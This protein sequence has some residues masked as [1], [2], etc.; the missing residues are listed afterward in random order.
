MK[1][2]FLC[3]TRTLWGSARS[4]FV[5]NDSGTSAHGH[6][7]KILSLRIFFCCTQGNVLNLTHFFKTVPESGDFVSLQRFLSQSRVGFFVFFSWNGW[8]FTCQVPKD[9]LV[10]RSHTEGRRLLCTS[11]H[12]QWFCDFAFRPQRMTQRHVPPLSGVFVPRRQSFIWRSKAG[13]ICQS[14]F[15]ML[16]LCWFD[17][18]ANKWT[19]LPILTLCNACSVCVCVCMKN[20]MMSLRWRSSLT[21]NCS[22]T[23]EVNRITYLTH[24][25]FYSLLIF[26]GSVNFR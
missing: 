9:S 3:K 26:E 7:G 2:W 25:V 17:L 23:H 4:Y 18:F 20:T 8:F 15:R 11:T 16:T 12:N 13:F 21:Q 14:N 10:R 24:F 5:R 19:S 6:C 22:N 1:R